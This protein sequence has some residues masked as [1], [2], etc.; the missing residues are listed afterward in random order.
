MARSTAVQTSFTAGIFG[1]EIEDRTEVEEYYNAA[2]DMLNVD[3]RPG[4]GLQ[5]RPG[6]A[7]YGPVR[8]VL[9]G[10]DLA[11]ATITDGAQLGAPSGSAPPADPPPPDVPFIPDL[12]PWIQYSEGGYLQP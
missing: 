6:T 3:P 10:I 7:Y 5:L 8:R 4:G 1:K 11:A 12:P 2:R 9:A